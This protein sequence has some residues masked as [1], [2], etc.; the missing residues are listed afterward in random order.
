MRISPFILLPVGLMALGLFAMPFYADVM[1]SIL[2]M[3]DAVR[4]IC[5]F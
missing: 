5:G 4:S 3:G 1:G 2:W